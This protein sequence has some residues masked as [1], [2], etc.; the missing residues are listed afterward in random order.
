[1]TGCGRTSMPRIPLSTATIRPPS[2]ARPCAQTTPCCLP[3]HLTIQSSIMTLVCLP[4]SSFLSFSAVFTSPSLPAYSYRLPL[5]PF[6][7]RFPFVAPLLP[8][9]LPLDA[10]PPLFYLNPR[11]QLYRYDKSISFEPH[12]GVN[13]P[14]ICC[15]LCKA[16]ETEREATRCP[17]FTHLKVH[18]VHSLVLGLCNRLTDAT[19]S[20]PPPCSPV[21]PAPRPCLLH[22]SG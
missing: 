7:D 1:M 2:P 12:E 21:G 3:S 17:S 18:S 19:D 20:P 11:P 10:S 22:L 16:V 9:C 6:R 15:K 14:Q 13:S 5:T 4:N 8:A